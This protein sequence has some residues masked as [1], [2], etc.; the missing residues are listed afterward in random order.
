[1]VIR[2]RPCRCLRVLEGV[3]K[4]QLLGRQ[5]LNRTKNE[6]TICSIN[7]METAFSLYPLMPEFN[8]AGI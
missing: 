3:V 6:Q 4:K 1:M 5:N 8:T 7:M 2:W